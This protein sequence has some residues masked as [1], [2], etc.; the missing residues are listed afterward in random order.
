MPSDLV[1]HIAT[2]SHASADD[3]CMHMHAATVRARVHANR[4]CRMCLPHAGMRSCCVM[5]RDVTWLCIR[6]AMQLPVSHEANGTAMHAKTS[7]T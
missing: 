4:I 5:E 6:P 3:Q 7:W 2:T 1:T